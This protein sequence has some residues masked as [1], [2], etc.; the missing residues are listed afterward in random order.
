MCRRARCKVRT[1]QRDLDLI[2]NLMYAVVVGN[3]A[4]LL[5]MSD[6]KAGWLIEMEVGVRSNITSEEMLDWAEVFDSIA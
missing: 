5:S 3:Y 4:T 6:M 1:L 2:A